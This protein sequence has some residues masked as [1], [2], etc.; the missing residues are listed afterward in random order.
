MS[1]ARAPHLVRK[2]SLIERRSPHRSADSHDSDGDG[3]AS[4]LPVVIDFCSAEPN[5]TELGHALRA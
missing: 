2:T 3:A 4:R 1:T 5:R